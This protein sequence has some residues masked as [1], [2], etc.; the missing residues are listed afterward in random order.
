MFDSYHV[1]FVLLSLIALLASYVFLLRNKVSKLNAHVGKLKLQS[2]INLKENS[3]KW[4]KESNSSESSMAKVRYLSGISHELRTPLNV[5]MGYVQLLDDQARNNDPNKEKY[6]LMRH[7][8]EHL[9]HLIEG[10]LEFS[11]IEAGKLKVKLETINLHDL[12]N[13]ITATFSHQAIQK[14]LKFSSDIDSKLP[15][16]VKSDYKRLQQILINLMSNA[17]KFTEEGQVKFTLTYRNQVATFIIEDTGCGIDPENSARIFEPFERIETPHKPTRGTGLGLAITRL[18]VELLG[19]EISVNSLLN[20][21][22][23]FIVKLMLAPLHNL[24]VQESKPCAT[25]VV[26]DK[27]IVSHPIL[28]VDDEASHRDLLAEILT[29]NHFIVKKV[30]DGKSAQSV[31]KQT[32]YAMAIIDV[33]MPQMDGWQL[34][35]WIKVHAPETKVMMLSANPRDLEFSSEK[36][37]DAY[38]TKPVKIKQLMSEIHHLLDLNW[39]EPNHNNPTTNLQGHVKLPKEDY[40][41]LL[42]MLDIGHINGIENYLEKLT[43]LNVITLQ[44]HHQLLQPVKQMNLTALKKMIDHA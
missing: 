26:S 34:A 35:S 38:S 12:V 10:V 4:V 19:G 3:K 33:S 21:G 20:Q 13:Q 11:T 15:Q 37:Y 18:L 23:E 9:N 36:V 29:S 40:E 17:I 22:S 43:K 6:T 25:E 44:Q 41:A 39:S 31:L 1:L 7:N 28:V 24:D 2:N 27:P 5:I 32:S 14:G 30:S 16:F 8:C 42:N